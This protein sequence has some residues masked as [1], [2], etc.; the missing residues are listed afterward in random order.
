MADTPRNDITINGGGTVAAGTYEN[1]TINGT[2]TVSGDVVCTG[3]ASTAL[4]RAW[5]R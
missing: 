1:V 5:A 4:R 3:C 2:G